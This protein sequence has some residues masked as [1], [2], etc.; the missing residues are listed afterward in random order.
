MVAKIIANNFYKVNGFHNFI[1]LKQGAK[2]EFF[3]LCK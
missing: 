2:Y 3:R 1:I